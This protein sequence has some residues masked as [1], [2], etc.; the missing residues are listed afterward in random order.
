MKKKMIQTLKDT[1][2]L[3]A[4]SFVVTF[5]WQ[6]LELVIYGKI[7]PRDVDTIIGLVLG[8]SIYMNIKSF[9]VL[10]RV[11]KLIDKYE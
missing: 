9:G 8:I 10:R 4:I 1:L 6:I 7:E 11:K 3:L 2:L 5:V